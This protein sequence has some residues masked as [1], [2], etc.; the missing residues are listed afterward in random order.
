MK[1]IKKANICKYVNSF[2]VDRTLIKNYTP[3]AG[4]VAI[5]KILEI[6]SMDAIQDFEGRNCN[7]FEGDQVMLA[8]G[9]R[10]ATN[11][12]EAYVPKGYQAEYD[13]VSKGGVVG[14]VASMYFKLE[15]L[16]PTKLKLEG[17][18]TDGNKVINAIY[19]HRE[20]VRFE[21]FKQNSF[22]TILSLGSSMDSGKTTTAAF[23]CRGMKNSGHKVAYVKLT[24][25]V[26]NKDKMLCFDC[27][28]DY[29][30][31]FSEFGYPST[32]LCSVDEILNIYA[33]LLQEVTEQNPDYLVIEIADGLYQRETNALINYLPFTDSMDHV[34][35]SC[36]DSLGVHTGVGVLSPIFGKK[37][38][39][40][41]GLFTG[42]PLLVNEVERQCHLPVLTLEKLANGELLKTLL[43]KHGVKVAV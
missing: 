40:L 24:G 22:K 41:G 15:D 11:Q 9:N 29:V 18:V 23:L 27:G 25:T 3:K 20:A 10:Y 13:L 35:L 32:Y 42:S 12:F 38:F 19:H 14:N 16:G 36:S 34:I 43:R 8:F 4:D 17:Y 30:S 2:K 21:P 1:K 28:A 6:G 33:G 5:F 26:F 7:I 39:A 31:D 37:L